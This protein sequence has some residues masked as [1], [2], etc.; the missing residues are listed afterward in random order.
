M[1]KAVRVG[2]ELLG[3]LCLYFV[4]SM[5]AMYPLTMWMD[6]L[7]AE[8]IAV[9]ARALVM[10]A[11]PTTALMALSRLAIHVHSAHPD[12]PMNEEAGNGR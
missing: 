3:W 4:I 8:Q 6:T 11:I 1:N 10:A 2:V 12:I 9:G 7:T 5:G